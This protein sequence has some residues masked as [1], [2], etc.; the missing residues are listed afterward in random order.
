MTDKPIANIAA[1]VRQRL[2]NL[3]NA[4]GGDYNALLTQLV[5]L[6]SSDLD[7]EIL[8]QAIA[9]TFKRRQT[10]LPEQ[11]PFGYSETKDEVQ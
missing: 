10:L 2:M 6:R 3:R 11:V 7:D 5:I 4:Q 9:A 1:S 8:A